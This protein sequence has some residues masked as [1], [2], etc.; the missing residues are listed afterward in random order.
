[1]PGTGIGSSV[2]LMMHGHGPG[3]GGRVWAGLLGAAFLA[4]GTLALGRQMGWWSVDLGLVG[5]AAV[6]LLGAGFLAA[7]L[8]WRT[9]WDGWAGRAAAGDD[10]WCGPGAWHGRSMGRYWMVVTAGFFVLAAYLMAARG[11]G[12]PSPGWGVAGPYWLL[13]VGGMFA[14]RLATAWRGEPERPAPPAR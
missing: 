14:L 12:W 9:A 1:M 6:L 8:A 11:F 7:A 13:A 10:A 5:A 4:G 3:P 2:S